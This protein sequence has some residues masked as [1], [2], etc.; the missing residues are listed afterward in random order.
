[1]SE[2]VS[3]TSKSEGQ[4][5]DEPTCPPEPVVAQQP[6]HEQPE[7][8][9]A[10]APGQK[11]D[12]EEPAAEGEGKGKKNA[13]WPELEADLEEVEQ[14]KT[15][16]ERGDGPD[17]KGKRLPAWDYTKLLGSGLPANR[18]GVT[19][20]HNARVGLQLAMR[21]AQAHWFLG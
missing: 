6:S 16:R 11:R 14:P 15:G 2:D 7:Q 21:A 18:K 8:V 17:V 4:R 19:K 20:L 5:D 3:S 10:D 9:E 12:D 1:M 13:W